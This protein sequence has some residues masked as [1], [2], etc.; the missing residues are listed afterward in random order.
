MSTRNLSPSSIISHSKMTVSKYFIFLC[1]LKKSE[2][3]TGIVKGNFSRPLFMTVGT[4]MKEVYRWGSGRL[5]I[6]QT[7]CWGCSRTC[8][9]LSNNKGNY[10]CISVS[11][12]GEFGVRCQAFEFVNLCFQF[13]TQ[14][15]DFVN[16]TTHSCL[17]ILYETVLSLFLHQSMLGTVAVNSLGCFTRLS[18]F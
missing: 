12:M 5:L 11:A 4:I 8:N 2:S 13:S 1:S 7:N 3:F 10:S 6:W 15:V 16:Q 17:D 14:V 9:T 18:L